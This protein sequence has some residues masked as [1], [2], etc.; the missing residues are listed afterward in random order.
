MRGLL[1]N[2]QD[3]SLHPPLR[4]AGSCS[5]RQSLPCVKEGGFCR[6]QKTKR[7]LSP[8]AIFFLCQQK[9][10]GKKNR[11]KRGFKPLFGN[12][13]SAEGGKY[14]VPQNQ[15]L[16]LRVLASISAQDA[17]VSSCLFGSTG[18]VPRDVPSFKAFPLRGRWLPE[19][20]TDEVF[21]PFPS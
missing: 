18:A 5:R 10:Y 16:N 15:N 11:P 19:G 17:A 4:R 1:R 8:T 20:Q 9:E 3:R 2:G 6:R 7:F 14:L 21:P 12:S 13:P